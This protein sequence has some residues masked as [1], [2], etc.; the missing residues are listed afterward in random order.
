MT[1]AMQKNMLY[2]QP[3]LFSLCSWIT[4]APVIAV[5][6]KTDKWSGVSVSIL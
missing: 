2:I 4:Q 5:S 1:P 3:N 6:R